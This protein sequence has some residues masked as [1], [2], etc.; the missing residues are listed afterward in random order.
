MRSKKLSPEDRDKVL[1]LASENVKYQSIAT[2]FG[3]SR[4]C[5]KSIVSRNKLYGHLPPKVKNYKRLT[6]GRVGTRLKEIV[7]E[8]P[9][10]PYRDL[11]AELQKT[12][13]PGIPI[14]SASTCQ[15]FLKKNCICP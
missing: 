14:P 12:M 4:S 11:P 6:G 15:R 5:V 3:V 8:N 13:T 9:Q 10:I 2:T 1:S 7:K